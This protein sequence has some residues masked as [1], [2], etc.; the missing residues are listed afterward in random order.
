M[1]PAHH[2]RASTSAPATNPNRDVAFGALQIPSES[3]TLAESNADVLRTSES[4]N[5]GILFVLSQSIRPWQIEF[6]FRLATG[7]RNTSIPNALN[8]GPNL[9]PRRLLRC[10]VCK[11]SPVRS[12]RDRLPVTASAASIEISRGSDRPARRRDNPGTSRGTTR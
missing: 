6:A 10:A 9:E 5:R 12:V 4:S 1:Q 7:D 2:A 3:P 8:G 11:I